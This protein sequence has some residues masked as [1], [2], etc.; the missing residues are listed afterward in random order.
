MIPTGVFGCS[1][2]QLGDRGHLPVASVLCLGLAQLADAGGDGQGGWGGTRRFHRGTFASG[3]IGLGT[4]SAQL[5]NVIA[6]LLVL[7]VRRGGF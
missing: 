3:G 4:A 2:Q 7:A 1:V 6:E 5:A